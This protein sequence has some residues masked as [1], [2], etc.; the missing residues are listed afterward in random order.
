MPLS[1]QLQLLIL[2]FIK[3]LYF[4][5][6]GACTG[7]LGFRVYTMENDARK[8]GGVFVVI[9]FAGRLIYQ[10]FQACEQWNRRFVRYVM[11]E[12][13]RRE[14]ER[15]L[16]NRQRGRIPHGNKPRLDCRICFQEF[17][18]LREPLILKE[19]GHTV[20]AC[21]AEMLYR[22]PKTYYLL[23]PFCREVTVLADLDDFLPK[24]YTIIQYLEEQKKR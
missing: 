2:D 9:T 13:L 4:V 6:C 16:A 14:L 1:P 7:Y 18:Y 22:N 19:C 11:I 20:C 5:A 23:C 21:C 15:R 10:L 17:N 12:R 24:N 3:I 8:F